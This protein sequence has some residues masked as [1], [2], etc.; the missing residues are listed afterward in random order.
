V[1]TA[2]RLSWFWVACFVDGEEESRDDV[3][4]TDTLHTCCTRVAM[5]R[6]GVLLEL[7]LYRL[8]KAMLTRRYGLKT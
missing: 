6:P 8:G 4:E 5:Q 7:V 3:I 1:G 2:L